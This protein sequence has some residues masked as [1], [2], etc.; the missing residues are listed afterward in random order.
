MITFKGALKLVMWIGGENAK[1]YRSA[2]VSILQRYYAG[3]RS[4]MEE[5]LRKHAENQ[6]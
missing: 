1:I 2:M 3:D 4:L 5:V 6:K